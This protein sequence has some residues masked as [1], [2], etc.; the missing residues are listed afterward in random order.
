VEKVE[1]LGWENKRT[2]K[3]LLANGC[4]WNPDHRDALL[5]TVRIKKHPNI[6]HPA[7]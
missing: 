6:A 4:Q 5:A 1:K 2:S 3:K 7:V